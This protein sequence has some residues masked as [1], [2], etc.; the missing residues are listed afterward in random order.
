MTVSPIEPSPRVPPSSQVPS[1]QPPGSQLPFRY[2]LLLAPYPR[3]LLE[4]FG[5]DLSRYVLLQRAEAR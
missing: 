2:R 4:E 1:A 5:P 3:S